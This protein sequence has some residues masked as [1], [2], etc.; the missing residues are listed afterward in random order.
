[1]EGVSGG[2][3]MAFK[4]RSQAVARKG[5][6]FLKSLGRSTD[7]RR[8]YRRKGG[9]LMQRCRRLLVSLGWLAAL[10]MAAGAGFKGN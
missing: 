6:I 5:D 9:Y 4:C 3:Q 10:L 1:M 7:T 2:Q 8:E